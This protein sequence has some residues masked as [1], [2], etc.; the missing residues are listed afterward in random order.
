MAQYAAAWE[1]IMAKRGAS[2][3]ERLIASLRA[4]PS[5]KFEE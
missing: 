5:I 4:L 3:E 2:A 1:G